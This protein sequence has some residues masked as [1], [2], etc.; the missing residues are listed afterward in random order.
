MNVN[1][2]VNRRPRMLRGCEVDSFSSFGKFDYR[3]ME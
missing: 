2:E 1:V 3:Y